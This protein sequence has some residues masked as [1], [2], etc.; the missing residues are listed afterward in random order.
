M[1]HAATV[2]N[3][4]VRAVDE[5][6]K[7]EFNLPLGLADTAKVKAKADFHG[8]QVDKEFHKVQVLDPA[9]GT[10]TFLAE[11]IRFIYEENFKNFNEGAWNSYVEKDLIPRINGFELLMASY[12][13]AHLKLDMLLS[14]T[15]YSPPL[16]GWSKTGV[17]DQRLN[18]FLTNSLEEHHKDTGTLF[19]NWLSDE[20][21]LANQIKRDTPVMCVI[22]NPPYSVSSSN[23]G[24]WIENLLKDYKKDLNE[25]NIQ[26]LSDDYIKFIRFGQHFIDKNGEGI[27]AYISNNSFIDGI[28]HRQMRKNLL[29]SFDKIYILDLHGN[30]KKKEVSPDGTPDQNVF[31]IMQGVSINIFVKTNK[32]KKNELG[33][34]FHHS[35]QGKRD[36]KYNFLNE[37][38]INLI[39]WNSLALR[40]PELYFVPKNFDDSEI[41]NSGFKIDELFVNSV[42]G[43]KT[44]K[45]NV[46]IHSS[47][48]KVELMIKDL[49]NQDIN[50]F[51]IK[52]NV[53]LDS[54]DWSIERSKSDVGNT[55]D[56]Q[57]IKSID[58][59]AF[60]RKYLYYT[61]KTNGIVARPRFRSLNCMVRQKNYGLILMR[62]LVNTKELKS[63][64][65][66]NTLIDINFY[67]FQSYLFP[68]YNF[69]DPTILDPDERIPNFNPEILK[70]IEEQLGMKMK[71]APQNSPLSEGGRNFQKENFDGVFPEEFSPLDLLD[72]IYAVLHSPNYREKYKEFLKIDFPRVPYPQASS[73]K[74]RTGGE[75]FW[76][77]VELGVQIRKLHLLE[78]ISNKEL[79]TRFPVSGDNVVEKP[80]FVI[81]RNDEEETKQSQNLECGATDC[82]ATLAKTGK[83]FIN[84][85]Q[86]FENVPEVA[87]NFYIGGYQPAQKWLKDR[88]GRALDFNDIL[89]YQKMIFALTKTDELMKQ[90]DLVIEL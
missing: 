64:F 42:S 39:P 71:D 20:S 24:P 27:L 90:I 89:H 81:A 12:S 57:K 77:L 15:G 44:S 68:L 1:V 65:I 84:K 80:S 36:F 66:T 4:I 8:K 40:L 9:T 56:Y 26:P 48:E 85:T 2:V 62:S 49:I 3:F 47:K 16:E 76:K 67:G 59:K 87:W 13:M 11:T 25:R 78:D 45:D 61:G 60:D 5:L 14:E 30:S 52:Y 50:D 75:A 34:V 38:K 55:F 63:V 33:E 51:R 73:Q 19:A 31:D 53:G 83:V 23:K 72:Y 69:K 17:V 32:K 29:E 22:G 79:K 18:I 6:L 54:R 86:Y 41:Y 74:E 28:I 10:G 43:I 88:K 21:T 7:S 70:K 35:L 37:K 82:L 58:Y 46:N